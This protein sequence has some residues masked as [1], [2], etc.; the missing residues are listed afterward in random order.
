MIFNKK[1][2]LILYLN[3]L[4]YIGFGSQAVVYLDK[5]SGNILK[6][7]YSFLEEDDEY[8]Y[9]GTSLDLLRFSH[10]KNNSFMAEF[11]NHGR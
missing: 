11:Y 6:I 3:K 10:I 9:R 8:L 1:E 7:F 5:K 4:T 2:D